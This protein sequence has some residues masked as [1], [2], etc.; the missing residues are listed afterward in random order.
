MIVPLV[1]VAIPREVAEN[2]VVLFHHPIPNRQIV[3]NGAAD[4][5]VPAIQNVQHV[6]DPVQIIIR[7]LT[8][9]T[10]IVRVVLTID[11][12]VVLQIR[13]LVLVPDVPVIAK[14]K[15]VIIL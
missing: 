13:V 3:E 12:H 8:H 5:V 4:N 10:L 9:P 14:V 11:I 6:N 7:P 2:I 15:T 1:R